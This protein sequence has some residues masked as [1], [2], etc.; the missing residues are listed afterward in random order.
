ML[1]LPSM[2]TAFALG[3]SLSL[4]GCTMLAPEIEPEL[5]VTES[6]QTPAPPTEPKSSPPRTKVVQV[7]VLDPDNDIEALTRY[8]QALLESIDDAIDSNEVGYYI[9]I[10]EARLIQH[11]RHKNVDMTR[12][13]NTFTL[14]IAGSEAFGSNQ[15]Q[16]KPGV[17][18]SLASI[19]DVLEE[20]RNI[21]I[22]IFGHTDDT[23]DA[24]YNQKLSERRAQSV[25]RY[26][27]KGGVATK[28]IAIIG[29]GESRPAATNKT[30][31]GRSRNRRIELL[32]SPLTR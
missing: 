19:T 14:L 1:V 10:L 5:Y 30:A 2:R 15:S 24:A 31:E 13:G 11:I 22:S 29:Y 4:A 6:R 7:A 8:R 9:D 20:Y 16:I 17:I 23:G 18:D 25:A 32:L 21:Q 28:R 27:I 26:L 12:E 3:L